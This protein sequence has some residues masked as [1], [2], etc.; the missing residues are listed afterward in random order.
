ME[1][2][3]PRGRRVAK[4]GG[5]PPAGYV[6]VSYS[7]RPWDYCSYKTRF[8]RVIIYIIPLMVHYLPCN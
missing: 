1:P 8:A 3:D 5:S 7:L 6:A 4:G 2:K